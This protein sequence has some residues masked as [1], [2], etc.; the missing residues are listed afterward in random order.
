MVRGKESGCGERTVVGVLL[1]TSSLK[2]RFA[3]LQACIFYPCSTDTWVRASVNSDFS[4]ALHPDSRTLYPESRDRI[5][6][7]GSL[8]IERSRAGT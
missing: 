6:E 2:R 1:L 4:E 3:F 7:S 8:K 5:Q